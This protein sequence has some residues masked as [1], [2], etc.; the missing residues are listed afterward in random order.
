MSNDT[1]TPEEQAII[2]RLK[3]APQPTLKPKAFDAIQAKLFLEMETPSLPFWRTKVGLS[4]IG[5]GVMIAI[6]LITIIGISV[7]NSDDSTP[8]IAPIPSQTSTAEIITPTAEGT[9]EVSPTPQPISPSP[10]TPTTSTS[11]G[12]APILV[13]EGPIS[14]IDINTITIFDM[15]IQIDPSDPILT[16]IQIGDRVRVDGDTQVNGNTINIVAV[17]ITIINTQIIVEPSGGLPANCKM[18]KNGKI[19]CKDTRRTTR[20]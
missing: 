20:D 9:L 5:G 19:T 8:T 2:E 16:Q 15:T 4:S 18:T 7:I 1:F 11:S 6:I 3:N 14:A 13:I 10:S 12:T 17:N